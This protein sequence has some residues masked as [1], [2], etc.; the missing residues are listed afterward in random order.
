MK[1]ELHDGLPDADLCHERLGFTLRESAGILGISYPSAWRL[2]KRG[3][4]KSSKALRKKIIPR[5]ELERF[6]RETL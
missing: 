4:L 5:T 1:P 2:W 3:L 6:L